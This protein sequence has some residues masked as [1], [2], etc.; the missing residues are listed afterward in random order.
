MYAYVQET[1]GGFFEGVYA[2]SDQARISADPPHPAI[3]DRRC[4]ASKM[5]PAAG[6]LVVVQAIWRRRRVLS[7]V[8]MGNEPP[9]NP[10][11]MVRSMYQM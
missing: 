2:L 3:S 1:A 10:A 6:A 5:N 7:T 11:K 8:T 9:M 4:M